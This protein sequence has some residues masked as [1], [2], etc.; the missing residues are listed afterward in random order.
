MV[1]QNSTVPPSL[2][3][4][5]ARAPAAARPVVGRDLADVGR[6]VVVVAITITTYS[7]PRV[8]E[9]RP[10]KARLTRHPQRRGAGMAA[11]L[12]KVALAR[13]VLP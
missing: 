6:D 2:A 11:V 7:P 5:A 10:S 3:G 13:V 1:S 12:D 9:T 4:P 8:R